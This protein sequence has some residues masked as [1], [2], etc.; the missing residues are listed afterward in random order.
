M[1]GRRLFPSS[2]S[3]DESESLES[4][5]EL[6]LETAS[7]FLTPIEVP[8]ST[9]GIASPFIPLSAPGSSIVGVAPPKYK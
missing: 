8:T 3:E 1:R 6:E 9:I 2:E 7:C 5:L 4:L